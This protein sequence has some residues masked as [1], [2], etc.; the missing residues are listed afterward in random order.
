MYGLLCQTNFC[1]QKDSS[2][3]IQCAKNRKKTLC[4]NKGVHKSGGFTSEIDAKCHR[5]KKISTFFMNYKL[6]VHQYIGPEIL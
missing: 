4:N 5:F 2:I 1:G 6:T 3:M